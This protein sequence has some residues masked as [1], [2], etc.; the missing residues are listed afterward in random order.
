MI[1]ELFMNDAN[2]QDLKD[3]SHRLVPAGIGEMK[4]SGEF[5][6]LI[7]NETNIM[8]FKAQVIECISRILLKNKHYITNI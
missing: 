7:M 2:M 3:T 5:V 4:L 1:E 6:D 8:D